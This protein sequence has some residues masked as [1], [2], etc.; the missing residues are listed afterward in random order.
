MVIV[1]K[2]IAGVDKKSWMFVAFLR[3]IPIVP[4]NLVNY[5]LGV[6][7][8]PFRIYLFTSAVFLIPL[9][10]IYTYFGYAGKHILT[11]PEQFYKGGGII[12]LGLGSILLIVIAL[13]RKKTSVK[14][15]TFLAE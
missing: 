11:K 2:L 3:L 9:E 5:G 1:N 6:T 10:I 7:G 15:N 14:N 4:F 8:I 13:I 12:L